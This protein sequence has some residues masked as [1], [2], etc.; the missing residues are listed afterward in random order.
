MG[1]EK[2][3]NVQNIG[4]G[5]DGNTKGG[6]GMM[7]TGSGG[8]G[9]RGSIV[10]LEVLGPTSMNTSIVAPSVTSTESTLPSTMTPPTTTTPTVS[11]IDIDTK[12]TVVDGSTKRKGMSLQRYCLSCCC[13]LEASNFIILSRKEW[14]MYFKQGCCELSVIDDGE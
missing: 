11:E 12:P 3:S 13:S 2:Q 7:E 10:S 1:E 6:G 14:S 9:D 8:H 5:D 4:E